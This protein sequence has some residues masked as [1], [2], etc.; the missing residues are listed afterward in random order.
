MVQA[1]SAAIS[2]KMPIGLVSETRK[3]IQ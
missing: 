3:I 1:S 2:M